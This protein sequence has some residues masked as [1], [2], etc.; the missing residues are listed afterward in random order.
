MLLHWNV[1]LTLS[2]GINSCNLD[3]R[4]IGYTGQRNEFHGNAEIKC[5]LSIA[6]RQVFFHRD[7]DVVKHDIIRKIRRDVLQSEFKQIIFIRTK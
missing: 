6:S 1:R 5:I 2:R 7:D 3:K 4:N